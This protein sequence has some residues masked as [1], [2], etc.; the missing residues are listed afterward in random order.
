MVFDFLRRKQKTQESLQKTREGLFGRIR[1]LFAGQRITAAEMDQAEE[2]LLAADVGVTTTQKLLAVLEAQRA[3]TPE[4]RL[5]ALKAEMTRMLRAV[6]PPPEPFPGNPPATGV[7]VV[8]VVGVNGVGKTTSIAKLAHELKRQ[9]RRPIIAAADTFRAAAVEQLQIWGKRV[10]TEVV[11]H[12]QGADPGAVVYDAYQAAKT[13][14]A[15]ILIVDT[16]GRL[17]TKHNLMEE[18]QKVRRV[19]GRLDTT[20]PHQ[21]LLVLDATTGQNGLAQAKAFLQAVQCTG[22]VLA[23]LDGTAKGGIVFSI[24]NELKLPVLFIGT[25][26]GVEDLAPFDAEEFV[27]GLF[28]AQAARAGA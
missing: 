27:E 20:A 1:Q 14:G 6:P 10:G 16:A 11:A 17:H 13:R 24:A 25:G 8:L 23:K 19:L 9:G 18:L 7:T 22:I 12:G 3:A 15:D 4:Q 5:A 21:T 26:E 2:L 28:T